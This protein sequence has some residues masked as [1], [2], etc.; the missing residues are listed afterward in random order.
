MR[1]LQDDVVVAVGV[2]GGGGVDGLDALKGVALEDDKGAVEDGVF[3]CLLLV[4]FVYCSVGGDVVIHEAGRELHTLVAMG[5][6]WI[7]NIGSGGVG[8]LVV[9]DITLL[10]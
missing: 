4:E 1:A 8:Q 5:T 3:G 2:S 9:R 7:V 10:G 6:K